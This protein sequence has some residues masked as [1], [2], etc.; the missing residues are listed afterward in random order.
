MFKKLIAFA[1]V[2]FMMG[3]LSHAFAADLLPVKAEPVLS[4]TAKDAEQSTPPAAQMPVLETR[5]P[6]PL[7][8]PAPQPAPEP[9]AAGREQLSPADHLAIDQ[10]HVTSNRVVIDAIPGRRFETAIFANT[11]SMDPV[12]DQGHQAIQFVPTGPEDIDDGDIITYDPSS[13]YPEMKGILI[14]HRVI[15]TGSDEQG[16]YAIV[17]GDNNPAPDPLKV[18]FP[19]VRRVLVGVLY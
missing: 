18:R 3:W 15:E 13:V 12:L 2:V 17:K 5:T 11:N 16:W 9:A 8:T 19:M 6:E 1:V 4:D 14:P 10:V 7:P